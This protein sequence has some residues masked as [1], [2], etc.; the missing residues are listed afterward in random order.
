MSIQRE[1][2]DDLVKQAVDEGK[3][4]EAGWLSLRY[5]TIPP[6]APDF[7]LRDMRV[8]FFAGAQHLWASIMSVLEPD[9]EPTPNDLRRMALIGTEL[10]SFAEQLQ[11]AVN[12]KRHD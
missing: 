3:L 5:L 7:Q 6:D 12:A 1:L 9:S 8:A 11:R 2:H 10:D 4:I